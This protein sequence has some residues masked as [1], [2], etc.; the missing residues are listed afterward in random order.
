[1][2]LTAILV[3]EEAPEYTLTLTENAADAMKTARQ[4]WLGS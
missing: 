4:S 2:K 3:S 1:M